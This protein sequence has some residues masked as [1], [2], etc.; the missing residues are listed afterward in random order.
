MIIARPGHRIYVALDKL[1]LYRADLLAPDVFFYADF[2]SQFGKAHI[3]ILA[4]YCF[5][6]EYRETR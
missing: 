6:V 3:E 4:N 1:V 2:C 5:I